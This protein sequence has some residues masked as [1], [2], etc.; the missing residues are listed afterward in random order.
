[1]LNPIVSGVEEVDH[2]PPTSGLMSKIVGRMLEVSMER[3]VVRPEGP[4]PGK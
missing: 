4:A 2:R 1:M 3:A